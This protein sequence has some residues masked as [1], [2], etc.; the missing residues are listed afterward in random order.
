MKSFKEWI[1][2]Q[3]S[4]PI[5]PPLSL[6]ANSSYFDILSEIKRAIKQAKAFLFKNKETEDRVEFSVYG[7]D[8]RVWRTKINTRE[9]IHFGYKN[10]WEK[11]YSEMP[12][13]MDMKQ[14]A[15]MLY[16]HRGS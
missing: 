14:F 1:A 15:T 5:Q 16:D 3:F 12:E 10:K 8:M 2:P 11:Q 9:K 7:F 4:S 6:N 13:Y